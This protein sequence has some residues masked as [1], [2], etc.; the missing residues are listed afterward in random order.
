M[1][2]IELITQQMKATRAR[3]RELTGL[4]NDALNEM[5]FEGAYAWLE[6]IGSDAYGLEHLPKTA[7]FWGFWKQEWHTVDAAFVQHINFYQIEQR[8]KDWYEA[9]HSNKG[10]KMLSGALINARFHKVIKELAVKR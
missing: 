1:T 7:E 5:I 3:V 10:N 8:K 6:S 9:M 4:T 2:H